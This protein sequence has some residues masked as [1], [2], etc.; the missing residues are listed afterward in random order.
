MHEKKVTRFARSNYIHT[1]TY[2]HTHV[3]SSLGF[4]NACYSS[5]IV[6][7]QIPPD[8]FVLVKSRATT[9]S[10]CQGRSLRE[11]WNKIDSWNMRSLKVNIVGQLSPPS[12]RSWSREESRYW[13]STLR[14]LN[15]MYACVLNVERAI[16]RIS[17]ALNGMLAIR[18]ELY[19]SVHMQ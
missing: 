9:T 15:L 4:V 16:H 14:Y 18:W 10:S 6:F 2:I 12:R 17:F 8:W 11:M 19:I 13:T 7:P 3:V 5:M 1:H